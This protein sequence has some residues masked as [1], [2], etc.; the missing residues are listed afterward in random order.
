M[1]FEN[2][3]PNVFH[4]KISPL[5]VSYKYPTG[6]LPPWITKIGERRWL[7]HPSKAEEFPIKLYE[8]QEIMEAINTPQEHFHISISDTPADAEEFKY[9]L[10]DRDGKINRI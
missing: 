10:K 9:Y 6:A 5:T 4:A 2:S 8:C 3:L 7:I 1:S